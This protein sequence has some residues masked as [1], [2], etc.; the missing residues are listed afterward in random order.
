MQLLNLDHMGY[1]ISLIR[2][3]IDILDKAKKSKDI[4]SITGPLSP[5]PKAANGSFSHVY[6]GS[7]KDKTTVEE[8]ATKNGLVY[9]TFRRLL[10][11]FLNQFYEANQLHREKYLRVQG[12]QKVKSKIQPLGINY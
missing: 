7:A 12:D 10:E 6:L 5:I 8:F 9:P 4:D 2:S 1:I 11:D 3:K